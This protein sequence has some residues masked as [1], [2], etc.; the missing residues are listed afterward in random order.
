MKKILI[1]ISTMAFLTMGC[2]AFAETKIAV[3]DYEKLIVGSKD[4]ESA[5]QSLKTKFEK[6]EK[7]IKKAEQQFQKD[8]EKFSKE[9]PTMKADEQKKE[10]QKIIAQQKK[11]QDMQAAFQKDINEAQRKT[12]DTI[13][14]KIGTIISKTAI[15][16]KIDLVVTKASVAYNKDSL[17]ITSDVLKNLKK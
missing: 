10:Q 12:M 13:F 1:A 15:S 16:K 11:L 7:D 9:S 17:D 5:K 8:V 6:R 3:V 4:L 2:L 14:K